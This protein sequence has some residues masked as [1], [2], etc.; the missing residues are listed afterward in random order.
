MADI[1]GK[2]MGESGRQ[3]Q[4]FIR[5]TELIPTLLDMGRNAKLRLTL[6]L[7]CLI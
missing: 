4:R 7:S 2:N 6:L 3:V 5:L 1:V